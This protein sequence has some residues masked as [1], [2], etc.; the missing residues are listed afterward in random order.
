MGSYCLL[1]ALGERPLLA[2]TVKNASASGPLNIAENLA[3]V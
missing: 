2:Q 1:T 3:F